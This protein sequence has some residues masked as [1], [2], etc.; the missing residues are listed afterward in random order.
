[1]NQSPYSDT[2]SPSADTL[3]PEWMQLERLAKR[4][5]LGQTHA[6]QWGKLQLAAIH[7]IMDRLDKIEADGKEINRG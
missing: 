4:L 5:G 7:N 6:T 1:M 2:T 3:S